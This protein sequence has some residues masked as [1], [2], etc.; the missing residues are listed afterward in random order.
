[1]L[2]Q[3]DVPAVFWHQ[4]TKDGAFFH[5]LWRQGVRAFLPL[6]VAQDAP[7]QDEGIILG[8]KGHLIFA[9]LSV[10]LEDEEQGVGQGVLCGSSDGK[11]QQE[12]NHYYFLFHISCLIL[13]FGFKHFLSPFRGLLSHF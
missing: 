5:G 4:E 12:Q 11:A 6:Q 7:V 10:Q 9:C 8:R 1:M 3:S 2:G 13:V